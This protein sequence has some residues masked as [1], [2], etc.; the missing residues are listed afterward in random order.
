MS[1]TMIMALDE[2]CGMGQGGKLPWRIPAELAHFRRTVA[3]MVTV[4]GVRTYPTLPKKLRKHTLV[5]SGRGWDG[6]G[7]TYNTDQILSA[8]AFRDIA[9]IGGAATYRA[10]L[11]YADKII[12]SVIH[13]SFSADTRFGL[14]YPND[15]SSEWDWQIATPKTFC[16]KSGIFFTVFDLTRK[17]PKGDPHGDKTPSPPTPTP[18]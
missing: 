10:F 4:C 6:V 12:M 16:D 5:W 11:P 8:A 13:G 3:D 2:E 18:Q 14:G 9:I 1:I 7:A 17:R 15:V